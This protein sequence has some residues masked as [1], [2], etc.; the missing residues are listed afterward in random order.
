MGSALTLSVLLSEPTEMI[1]GEFV[2]WSEGQP[3]VHQLARGDAVLFRSEKCHSVAKV[4]R[5]VRRSLVVELWSL[6][7]NTKNRYG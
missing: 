4:V 7:T 2:T 5:G 1:G 6:G 3:V